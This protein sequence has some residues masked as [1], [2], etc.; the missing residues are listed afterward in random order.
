MADKSAR[1]GRRGEGG[2][3]LEIVLAT[4]SSPSS[5]MLGAIG[6]NYANSTHIPNIG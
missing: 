1:Q 2:A 6:K 4:D 5:T 3:Q